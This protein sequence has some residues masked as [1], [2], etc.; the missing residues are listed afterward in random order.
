[1]GQI[2][3][4]LLHDSGSTKSNRLPPKTAWSLNTLVM[5][6]ARVCVGEIDLE[7]PSDDFPTIFRGR[8]VQHTQ[9]DRTD[10][11]VGTRWNRGTSVLCIH[12]RQKQ[13]FSQSS[14][15]QR[16]TRNQND[17]FFSEIAADN[18]Q[19]VKSIQYF[20]SFTAPSFRRIRKCHAR[21]GKI[22]PDEK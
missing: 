9:V 18:C 2:R 4:L 15:F 17:R 1:M 22:M 11:G 10:M 6:E 19:T 13:S 7:R 12:K 20:N 16:P 3:L 5:Y 21:Q 8:W 14:E